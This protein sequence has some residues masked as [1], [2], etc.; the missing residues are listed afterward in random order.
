MFILE[1]KWDDANLTFLH[2][3]LDV[4]ILSAQDLPDTDKFLFNVFGQ[5]L[6]DPYVEAFLGNAR[7]FKS[8]YIKNE[9]N[10]SWDESFKLLVCHHATS[11]VFKIKDK[12]Q[13]GEKLQ[14]DYCFIQYF[15]QFSISFE[16]T[17]LIIL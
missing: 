9:L 8:R 11:L 12:E 16:S 6:T 17:V 13:I 3:R 7:I 10:P 1:F 2:G 15:W 5:D 14:N 4:T